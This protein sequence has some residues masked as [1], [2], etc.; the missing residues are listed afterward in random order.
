MNPKIISSLTNRSRLTKI[1]YSNTTEQNKIL[2]IA[3]SIECSNMIV[4]AKE[5]YK[6]KLTKKLDDPSMIPKAYWSILTTLLNNKKMKTVKLFLISRKK[7]IS[8]IHTL[9]LNALQLTIQVHFHH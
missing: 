2:L 3:K 7:R 1:Y 6:N 9:P 5:R 4:E 8:S